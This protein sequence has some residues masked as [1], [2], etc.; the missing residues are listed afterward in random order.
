MS[1]NM[2]ATGGMSSLRA[3][4]QS[5]D[6]PVGDTVSKLYAELKKGEGADLTELASLGDEEKIKFFY[7]SGDLGPP[8]HIAAAHNYPAVM[9]ELCAALKNL[10]DAQKMELLIQEVAEHG[11]AL[12]YAAEN[13]H[14]AMVTQLLNAAPDKEY[15]LIQQGQG[16]GTPIFIAIR[17]L[18]RAMMQAIVN[19]AKADNIYSSF[20]VADSEGELPLNFVVKN[21]IDYLRALYINL[22]EGRQ[23]FVNKTKDKDSG[24][25]MHYAAVHGGKEVLNRLSR[26]LT[27]WELCDV[28][29][30]PGPGGKT[31]ILLAV[32]SINLEFL[33]GLKGLWKSVGDNSNRYYRIWVLK[34]CGESL[35]VALKTSC[36]E[37]RGIF[38]D[39][40]GVLD[41][42]GRARAI[43]TVRRSGAIDRSVES[44]VELDPLDKYLDNDVS[45]SAALEAL[46]KWL[47]INQKPKK[48]VHDR[49]SPPRPISPG[50]KSWTQ[51]IGMKA[52]IAAAG[53]QRSDIPLSIFAQSSLQQP[54][55]Q[56]QRPPQL[57]PLSLLPPPFMAIS[58]LS[59]L[60][61][62]PPLPQFMPLS[63]PPRFM[64]LP[65]LSLRPQLTALSQFPQQ[66][67]LPPRQNP[68]RPLQQPGNPFVQQALAPQ[69]PLHQQ[70]NLL[71][72]R[73]HPQAPLQ[74]SAYPF[75]KPQ[76]SQQHPASSTNSLLAA[77]SPLGQRKNL[78]L[79][80]SALGS[81][82]QNTHLP[83]LLA[84]QPLP[85]LPSPIWPSG[86]SKRNAQHQIPHAELNEQNAVAPMKKFQPLEKQLSTD[87][88]ALVQ[89]PPVNDPRRN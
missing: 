68:Q 5:N 81:N 37:I 56:T 74:Q 53:Q 70:L 27:A 8:L 18:D 30:T 14:T 75:L 66:Y 32:E 25:L 35:R 72:Q 79:P 43:E 11:S 65:L 24:C 76:Q 52:P 57:A 42:A 28:L 48:Y 2:N 73:P 47:F 26:G 31:P 38:S 50:N 78:P 17:N 40:L 88:D 3:I 82:A 36:P 49:P 83:N 69:Q 34:G 29:I 33:R 1:M 55:P 22:T 46:E 86:A 60:A 19:V 54:A 15:L 45:E 87:K 21:N 7:F 89:L 12:C 85:E 71:P 13:K 58:P 9:T 64:P 39:L 44:N 62:L 67:L 10:T 16:G 61:P 59:L 84:R 63:P 23:W 51:L 6:P 80:N 77:P 41:R 4:V 20:F